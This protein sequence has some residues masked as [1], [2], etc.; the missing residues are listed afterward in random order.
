VTTDA[1]DDLI[2]VHDIC[3]NAMLARGRNAEQVLAEFA[4][5]ME[6]AGRVQVAASCRRVAPLLSAWH[7]SPVEKMARV[8][9][10]V[11][12]QFVPNAIALV[13]RMRPQGAPSVTSPQSGVTHD[14]HR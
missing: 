5:A 4:A 11:R 2:V 3:T 6:S 10:L 14:V 13:E 9:D 1:F 7:W 12:E 8:N